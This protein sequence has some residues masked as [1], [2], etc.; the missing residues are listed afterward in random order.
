MSEL[1]E[2]A[3]YYAKSG[4]QV[5]PLVPKSK[6]PLTTRGIK[7]ATTDVQQVEAWW[8]RWPNA[9]IGVA[10]GEESGI[11]V[12]DVDVDKE[13][14]ID[15]WK[16][17][18]DFS[19]D[20]KLLPVTV[21][22][23]TPRG[24]AHFFYKTKTRPRNKNSF[25]HGIDIRSEGYYVLLPPSIHPNGGKYKWAQ[26]LAPW[27]CSY[28]EFPDFMRPVDRVAAPVPT[29][30]LA[31]PGTPV[32][33]DV[34]ER[35]KLYLA[36]C[37]PAV[38]GQAGH[39]KLF[40]AAGALVHGFLLSDDA[41]FDLL[42]REFNPHCQPPW[43][44][45]TPSD[46]K[47]FKR[48]I[49]EARRVPA[50][51]PA[52]WLLNDPNYAPF[53]NT[54]MPGIMKS[55]D[56]M[57]VNMYAAT[58][59][60]ED[61]T[62]SITSQKPADELRYLC[63]PTGLLGE[64]CA[65]INATTIQPQPFFT[66]ACA[67]AFCGVLFGR[68]IK[69]YLGARTNLYCMGI[70]PSSSGK[71]HA[72]NQVRRI[73]I[74]A[75]CDDL[76]GGNDSASDSAIEQDLAKHPAILY[77]W[78]EIGHMITSMKHG[79]NSHKSGIVTLLMKLYSL[80]G[81]IYKGKAFATQEQQVIQQPCCGVYGTATPDRFTAGIAPE[82][83]R[84][85]WIGRCLIFL[86]EGERPEKERNNANIPVPKHIVQSVCEWYSLEIRPDIEGDPKLRDYVRGE[87]GGFS[88]ILP[89][90]IQVPIDE[91]AERLL[92]AFDTEARVAGKREPDV[93]CLWAKAEENARK[94]ALIIA[95]SES[96]ENPRITLSVADYSVRLIRYLLNSFAEIILPNIVSSKLEHDKVRVLNIIR[97]RGLNGISSGE[98][99][100]SARWS[101]AKYRRTLCADLVEAEEIVEQL[102]PGTRGLRYWTVKHYN[103][104]IIQQQKE[105]QQ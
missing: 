101:D 91:D 39:D 48:K 66:L 81:T 30:P 63:Q 40:W 104:F 2:A 7:D 36:T 78:D 31:A 27:E 25:K 46:L 22:Q 4:W 5:F 80:S 41:A 13:R 18:A 17:V 69:D 60:A 10:C 28:G 3:L 62:K 52:G 59:T 105:Q 73:C 64:I 32:D 53:D 79:S 96:F 33:S 74:E 82:E 16:T 56:K 102:I 100:R 94:I 19:S 65:W 75:G 68:K 77:L 71:N 21:C 70:G 34:T 29:Q 92:C 1:R 88:P 98:L 95:A 93:D 55:I 12:V 76:I 67:L 15:G 103:E 38:Q 26:N 6:K 35:A 86:S 9:N 90:Q 45:D 11:H 72:P 57:I 24:G 8:N 54:I 61:G 84:D 47:D 14:G 23:T 99:A 49:S 83:L 87:P 44:L 97:D 51:K 42:S 50:Q 37:D 58:A 20:G 89:L 43:N 85:G